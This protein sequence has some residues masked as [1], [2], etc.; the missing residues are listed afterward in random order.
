M[1]LPE[2]QCRAEIEASAEAKFGDGGSACL[3]HGGDAA[4]LDEDVPGFFQPV[5][6]GIEGVV[7]LARDRNAV[8]PSETVLRALCIGRG[9]DRNR[10]M[11]D[12]LVIGA[13][14][15][16]LTL[17][18]KLQRVGRRVVVAE[19]RSVGAGASAT[20]LGV[21]AP[22]AP[23]NWNPKKEAQFQA[24]ASLPDYLAELEDETGMATGYARCGRL[25]PLAT[26]NQRAVWERR[27]VDAVENWRGKAVLER[28]ERPDPTWLAAEA[29]PFGAM[30]CGLSAKIDARGYLAALA[31]SVGDV[32]RVG[33]VLERLEDRRAIFAGGERIE[34]ERIVLA[35][36]AD[37]FRHLPLAESGEPAGRGEKGQAAVLEIEGDTGGR[38]IIFH[39]GTYVVPRGAQ[40][41]AV[42]A[43]SERYFERADATDAQLDEKISW[44]TALCP[45]L[46]GARVV[47]R[48]AAAR[49]RAADRGLMVGPH[50]VLNGVSLAT[51]G[52]K[53]GLAMAH[54]L[55]VEDL[56]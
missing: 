41:V 24:L 30:F 2:C 4:S 39:D 22:H 35:T 9:H 31:A 12:V 54:T 32:V 42:G 26:E 46:F 3:D 53:T 47:E 48:W 5:L 25:I 51:G 45:A 10:G 52:F 55:G 11:E 33:M 28:V 43:T 20:P 8:F 7:E 27:I 29:A 15:F 36:G 40:S 56:E 49:P 37:A 21:L 23:D 6:A 34:A 16:G 17:A 50:L 44:A 14:I 13:G 19:A 38:P 1:V 18:R